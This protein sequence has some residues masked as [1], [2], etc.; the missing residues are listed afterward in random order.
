[1]A[2]TYNDS[3]Q[4]LLQGGTAVGYAISGVRVTR[5]GTANDYPVNGWVMTSVPSSTNIA[6]TG[7]YSNAQA[8]AQWATNHKAEVV[9]L[10]ANVP[11]SSGVD[12]LIAQTVQIGL[13]THGVELALSVNRDSSLSPEEKRC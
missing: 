7:Q 4:A 5:N 6:D 3:V 2:I 11:K 9:K 8:Y 1:M 12:K 10:C 13:L